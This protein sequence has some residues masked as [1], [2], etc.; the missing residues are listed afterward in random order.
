MAFPALFDF[1]LIVLLE[2]AGAQRDTMIQFYMGT[3]TAGLA[4]HHA[5]PMIDKKVAADGGAGMNVDPRSAMGPFGHDS[6]NERQFFA[7][8]DVGQALDRNGFDAGIAD[9]DLVIAGARRVSLIGGSDVRLQ[10]FADWLQLVDQVENDLVSPAM[11]AFGLLQTQTLECFHT[12]AVDNAQDTTRGNLLDSLSRNWLF[13]VE[14][15]KQNLKQVFADLC[16]SPLGR[17]IGAID[18]IDATDLLVGF[19]DVGDEW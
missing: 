16:D 7:V 9:D 14:S 11:W 5:S 15:R 3:D 19:Q 12:K 1:S 2:A 17:Q 6:W 10:D 13:V 4:D 8:E 18:V